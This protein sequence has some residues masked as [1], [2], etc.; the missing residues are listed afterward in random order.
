MKCNMSISLGIIS[1]ILIISITILV[2]YKNMKDNSIEHFYNTASNN[3][4][5]S[6]NNKINSL[7]NQLLSVSSNPTIGFN[8]DP[9]INKS[10]FQKSVSDSIKNQTSIL[11]SGYLSKNN[12]TK[13]SIDDLENTLIDLE[14]I[15]NNKKTKNINKIKYNQIK[16]LNNG[17]EMNL[18]STPNTVFQDSTTGKI[19]NSHLVNVNNGCLSVGANDYDVYKCNDK[20]PKQYFKM[21]HIINETDY[22]KNIDKALPFDNVDKS[23]INYPFA[24]VKSTNNDE[25]LT[26]NH[27]TLT[28][29]PC[30]SFAAQRWIPI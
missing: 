6:N 12:S 11:S 20:N 18:I 19:T 5:I 22:A 21:Q 25:C 2:F 13:K 30:Y 7:M 16:S 17:M 24:M 10:E 8:I 3:L 27:G 14:N 26:N 9:E 4:V 23:N 15:I 1:I 28:V 29:Q